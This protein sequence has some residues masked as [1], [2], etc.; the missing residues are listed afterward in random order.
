MLRRLIL[1]ASLAVLAAPA[2]ADDLEQRHKALLE[3]KDLQFAFSVDP[4]P[5]PP[6]SPAWLAWLLLH[7][8][9]LVGFRNRIIVLFQWFW[10]SYRTTAAHASSRA[11]YAASMVRRAWSAQSHRS[12]RP[13]RRRLPSEP[14]PVPN[15]G[16]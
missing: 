3:R 4:P 5:S 8:M 7:L 1:A 6:Q 12:R 14:H 9:F 16:P 11:H 10:S 15:R 13:P 2:F